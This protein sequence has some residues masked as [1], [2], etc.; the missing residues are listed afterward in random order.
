MMIKIM[1]IV[2]TMIQIGIIARKVK[3]FFGTRIIYLSYANTYYL[4]E[5]LCNGNKI[6]RYN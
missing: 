4:K 1:V 5:M 3:K 2:T 6:L